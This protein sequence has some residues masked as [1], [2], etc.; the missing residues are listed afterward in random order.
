MPL[1]VVQFAIK[2]DADPWLAAALCPG[3]ARKS[4]TYLR[5]NHKKPMNSAAAAHGSG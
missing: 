1:G 5:M 2:C 4:P 3:A